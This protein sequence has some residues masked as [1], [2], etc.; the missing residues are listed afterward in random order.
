MPSCNEFYK[1]NNST[2]FLLLPFICLILQEVALSLLSSVLT[3]MKAL[4][5]VRCL[6]FLF[7]CYFSEQKEMWFMGG[8]C[9]E[10]KAPGLAQ[11]SS[12]VHISRKLETCKKQ[13]SKAFGQK[14]DRQHKWDKQK[15]QKSWGNKTGSR[16]QIRTGWGLSVDGEF[17]WKHHADISKTQG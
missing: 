11:K 5:S 17:G 14:T 16:Q 1:E 3:K 15:H 2:E 13:T 8:I 12:C 9:R 4:S 10:M 6:V 7:T